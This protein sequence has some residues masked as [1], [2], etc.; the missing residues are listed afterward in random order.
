VLNLSSISVNLLTTAVSNSG[1]DMAPG[2][3]QD[4]AV[5]SKTAPADFNGTLK[6]TGSEG[7]LNPVSC[8]SQAVVNVVTPGLMLTKT[9]SL[10]ATCSADDTNTATIINGES[11]W[12]CL[13]VENTGDVPLTNAVLD[14]AD[15]NLSGFDAGSFAIGEKK[16]FKFGSFE[17]TS[18][19]T[20]IAM[21]NA[22]VPT[23]KTNIGPEYSSATLT[24]LSADVSVDKSVD[25]RNIV[26]CDAANFDPQFCTEPNGNGLFD[27]TYTIIVS[28]NGPNVAT[29]VS[30]SDTL[31]TGFVYDSYDATGA[32]ICDDTSLPA[33]D[34]DIGDMDPSTSVTITVVGE[35]DPGEFDFPWT[36]V[37]N[38][39]CANTDP[40]NLDPKTSNNCDDAKTRLGTGATRT[41]GWWSTHPDGLHACLDESGGTINLGFL[42]IQTEG[43]DDAIDATVSTDPSK[44]GKFKSS[45]MTAFPMY[46]LPSRWPKA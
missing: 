38:Q 17:P 34:C 25:L 29:G 18:G 45:L 14:D 21:A 9:I 2:A 39:A 27:T 28:N 24:V 40:V 20:N 35:I 42:V 22:S 31:P 1:S 44:K 32:V 19:Y 46:L 26:I 15:I 33:F 5:G 11:V 4:I 10:D 3:S 36:I 23:T 30:L 7:G 16:T 41:I 8:Q 12:Y 37:T 13:E 6:L 43:G